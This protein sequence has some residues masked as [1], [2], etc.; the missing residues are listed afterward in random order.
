MNPEL[1]KT[2]N[3]KYPEMFLFQNFR[4]VKHFHFECGD[5]WFNII[6]AMCSTIT[7]YI[8]HNNQMVDRFTEAQDMIDNGHK[9]KVPSYLLDMMEAIENGNG[10]WP[11]HIDYPEFRQV[12]EKFGTL[13]AYIASGDR[14]IFEIIRF[15]QIMSATTCEVC[16]NIGEMRGGG[17]LKTLCDE[18]HTQRQEQLAQSGGYN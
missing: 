15:A 1:T 4:A 16:G 2:L 18:H 13:S 14:T 5:G 7:D 10:E 12:K 3:E 9:D 6:D 11:E 8:K 17:W